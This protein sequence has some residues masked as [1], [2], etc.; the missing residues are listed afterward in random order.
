M[1]VSSPARVHLTHRPAPE[2]P[3]LG[4]SRPYLTLFPQ[5]WDIIVPLWQ[6]GPSKPEFGMVTMQGAGPYDDVLPASSWES[7]QGSPWAW[8]MEGGPDPLSTGSHTL[9]HMSAMHFLPP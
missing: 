3:G 2:S 6:E 5:S 1:Q 8:R 4:P 9:L 7:P